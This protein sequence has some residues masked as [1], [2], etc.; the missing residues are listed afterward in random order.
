M[1]QV[2]D[3]AYLKE[4]AAMPD[5]FSRLLQMQREY[6]ERAETA[7]AIA[8]ACIREVKPLRKRNR[9]LLDALSREIDARRELQRELI[10]LAAFREGK[11]G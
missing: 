11:D 3:E 10:A 8:K 7:E 2:I 5:G 6:L 4:I 9:K 1:M